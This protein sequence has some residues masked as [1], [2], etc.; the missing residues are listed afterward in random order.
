MS[1]RSGAASAR[2]VP[3]EDASEELK[4]APPSAEIPV[5]ARGSAS[6][7]PRSRTMTGE[8]LRETGDH[9]GTPRTPRESARDHFGAKGSSV[10]EA[11][12]MRTPRGTPRDCVHSH[13]HVVPVAA[14][15]SEDMSSPVPS[16]A[17][18]G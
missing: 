18:D 15:S 2:K 12:P 14:A 17:Y 11:P 16:E 6:S 3:T 1:H 4:Q 5:S 8:S 10:R 9:P 13:L 7:L